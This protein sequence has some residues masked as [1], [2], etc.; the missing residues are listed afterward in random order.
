MILR[1]DPPPF[2]ANRSGVSGRFTPEA[3]GSLCHRN[4]G[5]R[6][7]HSASS[8]IVYRS[9]GDD[10][11]VIGGDCHALDLPA[12]GRR[13]SS[14]QELWQAYSRR[15]VALART[16]LRSTR[17]GAADEEDVGL[18]PFD[19]FC[20]RGAACGQFPR[21]D[22]RDDLWQLLLVLTVRKAINLAHHEG[23]QSRGAG[24]VRL[25]SELAGPELERVLGPEPTPELAVQ[26]AD[27]FE[28]LLDGLGDETLRAVALWK[29]AKDTPTPRSP[30]G[31]AVSCRLSSA[32][33]AHTAT[34]D[35]CRVRRVKV[36]EDPS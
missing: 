7:I 18:A 6:V 26:A 19:S 32:S 10:A 5:L 15:L 17:R 35:R 3:L 8:T 13:R 9:R 16:R 22:D 2:R 1:H 12:Q 24:R 14:R 29:S 36:A 23:C 31:S 25:L 20:R 21:L 28:R 11:G 34:V 33:C 4:P 30:G 27:E